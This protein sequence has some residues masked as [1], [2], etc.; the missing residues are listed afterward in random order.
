M[1]ASATGLLKTLTLAAAVALQALDASETHTVE[2]AYHP[3]CIT[4]EQNPL[5][6]VNNGRSFALNFGLFATEDIARGAVIRALT[7]HD[8]SQ[9]QDLAQTAGNIFQ[10][11]QSAKGVNSNVHAFEYIRAHG[12]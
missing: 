3:C 8:S 5:L 1:L 9:E 10:M 4:T 7:K 2:S 12:N 11:V 6:K